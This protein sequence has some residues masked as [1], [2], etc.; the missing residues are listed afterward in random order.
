MEDK[1]IFTEFWW[2]NLL[3]RSQSKRDPKEI[4]YKKEGQIELSQDRV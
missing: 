1:Y 4:G 3:K 2:G